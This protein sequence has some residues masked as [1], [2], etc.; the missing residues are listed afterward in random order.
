MGIAD[1]AGELGRQLTGRT[2]LTIDYAPTCVWPSHRA[3]R[4]TVLTHGLPHPQLLSAV[5]QLAGPERWFRWVQRGPLV[6]PDQED[7]RAAF[8]ELAP[9]PEWADA[10]ITDADDRSITECVAKGL[11]PV[12]GLPSSRF[13]MDARRALDVVQPWSARGLALH[14]SLGRPSS[15]LLDS[16]AGMRTRRCPGQESGRR[17][18]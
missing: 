11:V 1:S 5:Q 17:S 3:R 18:A 12:V 6:D 4:I 16:A 13:P 8:D 2:T 10:V 7:S 14:L 15:G 9:W